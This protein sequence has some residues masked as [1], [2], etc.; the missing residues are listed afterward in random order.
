MSVLMLTLYQLFLW[1]QQMQHDIMEENYTRWDVKHVYLFEENERK[2]RITDIY[3]VGG[4][5]LSRLP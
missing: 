5:G 4:G 1:R 2:Y 3:F